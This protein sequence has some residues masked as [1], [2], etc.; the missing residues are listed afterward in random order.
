MY[1]KLLLP[2]AFFIHAPNSVWRPGSARTRLGSLSAP[3][4]ALWGPTSE[5][6]GEKKDGKGGTR[7]EGEGRKGTGPPFMDPRYAPVTRGALDRD[8]KLTPD[9]QLPK[10]NFNLNL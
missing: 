10:S 7:R 5:G 1:L 3:L 4:A 9:T 2:E 6:R 8:A